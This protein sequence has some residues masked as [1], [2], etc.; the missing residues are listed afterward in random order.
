MVLLLRLGANVNVRDVGDWTPLHIAVGEGEEKIAEL[1]IQHGA[2]VNAVTKEEEKYTPLSIA[3][4]YGELI[5]QPNNSSRWIFILQVNK[6]VEHAHSVQWK[7]V[8]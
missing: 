3:A 7:S 4:K 8:F 5:L 1:L 2:N 6:T